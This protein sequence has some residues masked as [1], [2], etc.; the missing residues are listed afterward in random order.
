MQ[1]VGRGLCTN[2]EQCGDRRVYKI[3]V[4]FVFGPPPLS[5]AKAKPDNLQFDRL[6]RSVVDGDWGVGFYALSCPRVRH[7][8]A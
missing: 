3:F 2:Y 1:A 4:G 6:A 7:P 8:R 5:E